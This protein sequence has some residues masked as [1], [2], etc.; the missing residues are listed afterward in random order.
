MQEV[1]EFR[2]DGALLED[3]ANHVRDLRRAQRPE[4]DKLH[5]SIAAPAL[6]G[7]QQRVLAVHLVGPVGRDHQ[8]VRRPQAPGRVVEQLA[9][10]RVGP[11][12]VFEDEKQ[13]S[14]T[15]GVAEKN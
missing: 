15:G 1:A 7:R 11:L 13:R 12:Q 14:V 4:L 9:R 8:D 2:A 3:R 6:D 10:R 5:L